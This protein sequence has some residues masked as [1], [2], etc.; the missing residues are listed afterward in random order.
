MLSGLRVI[1][2]FIYQVTLFKM[3]EEIYQNLTTLKVLVTYFE[4]KENTGAVR[5]NAIQYKT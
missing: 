5:A 4:I 3:T 1:V 2:T